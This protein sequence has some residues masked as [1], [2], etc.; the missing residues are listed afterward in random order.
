LGLHWEQVFHILLALRGPDA[1]LNEL[2]PLGGP[3]TLVR[4]AREW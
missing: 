3:Q 1:L 4:G 2:P